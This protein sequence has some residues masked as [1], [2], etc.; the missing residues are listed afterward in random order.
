[1]AR[2]DGVGERV[3]ICIQTALGLKSE[4]VVCEVIENGWITL[5]MMSLY[6]EVWDPYST[7]SVFL[8]SRRRWAV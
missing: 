6:N 8:Y 3:S 2:V 4:Y 5:G 7:A 1:M